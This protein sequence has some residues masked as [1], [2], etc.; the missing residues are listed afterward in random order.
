[1]DSQVLPS[2]PEVSCS[3][4]FSL[5]TDSKRKLKY[6]RQRTAAEKGDR[7]FLPKSVD[8]TSPSTTAESRNFFDE[9]E[10]EFV[11][12]LELYKDPAI[13]V[14]NKPPGLPVQGGIGIKRSL[15]EL[16]AKYLKFDFTESP[17]LV[18]RLDRDSSGILVMGRTQ[19]ST[20][21]LHSV[22]REKTFGASNNVCGNKKILQKKYWALV[23]GS[24]RRREGLISVPLVK[25]VLDNGKSERITVAEN[26][27][28]LSAQHAVTEYRVIAS[29]SRGYSWLELSPLTGRKHQLRVHCAEVLG[30]PIVGDYKYG[31]QAHK[32]LGHHL[33]SVSD[34]KWGDEISKV[35]NDTF[36]LELES[37]SISDKQ[38]RLHLHCKEMSLP[39]ITQALKYASINS[40]LDTAEM[41][42]ITLEACLPAHMQRS[43][44]LLS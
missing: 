21:I 30:T 26:N 16:A 14:I 44:S 13:I 34:P 41:K 39:D 18:H 17:R 8:G 20:T 22:F 10:M 24:P 15:D 37:G 19:L 12:S 4:A 43:W 1:M 5:K 2:Y 40:D 36:A 31:W 33:D 38:F 7:I 9:K 35:K 28:T 27:N 29:S 11:R 25:V 23:I 3:E 32:K 6:G 42:S